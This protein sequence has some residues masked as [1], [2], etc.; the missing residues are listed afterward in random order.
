MTIE[1]LLKKALTLASDCGVAERVNVYSCNGDVCINFSDWEYTGETLEDI[2]LEAI[3]DL[4]ELDKEL[5]EGL[6]C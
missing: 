4:E 1:T 2:L 5:K 3:R 6:A